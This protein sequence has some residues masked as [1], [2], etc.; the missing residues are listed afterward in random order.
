MSKFF[1][2]FLVF[3]IFLL[4]SHLCVF[5][6]VV[7]CSPV[8][9]DFTDYVEVDTGND[10]IQRTANHVDHGATRNEDTYLY[11]DY[12]VGRFADFA[13]KVK[14]RGTF[15]V[16]HQ[17]GV[18]WMLANAV[19]DQYGLHISSETYV[20]ITMCRA[21][22]SGYIYMT[23]GYDGVRYYTYPN[24][25]SAVTNVWY[26]LLI[27]KSGTDLTCKIY[28][29]SEYTDLLVTLSL[30]LH[31]DWS[32]RYVYACNTFNDG[33]GEYVM[34]NDIE[35][36]DLQEPDFYFLNYSDVGCNSTML[37]TVVKFSVLWSSNGSLVSWVFGWNFSGSWVD[38]DSVDWSNTTSPQW[39]NVSKS[40]GFDVGKW[41]EVVSWRVNATAQ[42]NT[43][44]NTGLQSFVLHALVVSFYVPDVGILRVNSTQMSNSTVKYVYG[45]CL[46]VECLPSSGVSFCN[47]TE[48]EVYFNGNPSNVTFSVVNFM[49]DYNSNF[50]MVLGVGDGG[51]SEG[52]LSDYFWFGV[53]L[54]GV[55]GFGGWLLYRR[56]K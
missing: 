24:W 9:E 5:I 41:H 50:V 16:D 56:R 11:K 23:E 31:G 18:V 12:G 30:T 1:R 21:G 28:S 17:Y 27:E 39:S 55:V 51:Y 14:V 2:F 25:G 32:F 36:L 15:T 48:N 35:N 33:D 6:C 45:S 29:D 42:G 34:D 7:E 43:L 47:F 54:V 22:G 4:V 13:H 40:L 53:L 52:D 38:D 46:A 19:N 8:Y 44:N 49:V 37:G 10:R 26:Y 3:F 20:C